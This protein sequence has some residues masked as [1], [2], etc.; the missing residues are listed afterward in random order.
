MQEHQII[1]K[2]IKFQVTKLKK[3]CTEPETFRELVLYYL[4]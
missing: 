3:Y 4:R 2:W 1:N